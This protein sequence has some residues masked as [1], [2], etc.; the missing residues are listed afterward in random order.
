[1]NDENRTEKINRMTFIEHMEE[2]RTR[3]IRSLI[4]VTV[5]LLVC[6]FFRKP[7][8]EIIVQ[9]HKDVMASLDMAVLLRS[10]GPTLSFLPYLK[11]AFIAAIFLA[12]PYILYQMWSFIGAG[13]YAHEQ[14]MVLFYLPFSIFLFIGG[15]LFGYHVLIPKVLWFLAQHPSPTQV[16]PD[17]RI[18]DYLSFFLTLTFAVGA[19]FQLPIVM[20][21]INRLGIIETRDMAA[22]RRG[23]ILGAFVVG[24]LITPPD[25][26]SQVMLALP[27]LVLFEF[28]LILC[29]IIGKKDTAGDTG[30]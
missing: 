1:M 3:I 6:F 26:V 30:G 8:M 17:Y 22:R 18:D 16:V 4:M 29:R 2:L 27:M 5:C 19:I 9:P 28:G 25:V 12:S 15:I 24:A 20:L 13:L 14:R 23:I 7:V 10:A 21:G 11:V